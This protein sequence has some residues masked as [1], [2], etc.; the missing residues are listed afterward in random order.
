MLRTPLINGKAGGKIRD[1]R[2]RIRE[3]TLQQF[4]NVQAGMRESQNSVSF[5]IEHHRG[6]VGQY[7]N[8]RR[9]GAQKVRERVQSLLVEHRVSISRERMGRKPA[10][11]E[12]PSVSVT[13]SPSMVTHA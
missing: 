13:F 3:T 1:K 7:L 5:K 11:S 4:E 9:G 10:V 12:A 2:V 8:V 6:A